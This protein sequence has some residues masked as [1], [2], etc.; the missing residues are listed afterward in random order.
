[1]TK[2]FLLTCLF[3][4]ALL[5]SAC[6]A[7]STNPTANIHTPTPSATP[8]QHSGGEA[9]QL[10]ASPTPIPTGTPSTLILDQCTLLD[11]R[12]LASLYSS[13]EV[14]LP[15]PQTSQVDHAI[16][17]VQ[18]IP[19]IETSCTY[20]VFHKPGKAVTQ[21]L[22]ITYW[23]DTPNQASSSAWVQ[24]WSDAAANTNNAQA[25]PGLGDGAFFK[26]GRLTFKK[27]NAYVTI[28]AIGTALNTS[29]S[30]G[31]AQQIQIE[32]QIAQD[33]YNRMG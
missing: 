5:L 21:M 25:V 24:V 31:A 9:T 30:A 27:D 11:S 28:E 23:V 26:D 29:T 17:S 12:D 10:A 14:V 22:Q 33:A 8:F 1:M 32:K 3:G 7:I 20:Y 15:Q 19:V 13:A 2:L 18:K 4:L 16:F 6:Q